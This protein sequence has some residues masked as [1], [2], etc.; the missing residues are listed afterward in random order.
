M[1]GG[2]PSYC[3]VV[4]RWNPGRGLDTKEGSG[5]AYLCGPKKTPDVAVLQVPGG[6]D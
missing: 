5:T 3:W 6:L 4:G 2:Q 1:C